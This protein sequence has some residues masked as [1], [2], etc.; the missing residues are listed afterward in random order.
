M[1]QLNSYFAVSYYCPTQSKQKLRKLKTLN[2]VKEFL[3]DK[4]SLIEINH[5][6]A[7]HSNLVYKGSIRNWS[8]VG[9]AIPFKGPNKER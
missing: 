1:K 4:K 3:Q 6:I 5:C 7:N 9:E 8:K 2:M